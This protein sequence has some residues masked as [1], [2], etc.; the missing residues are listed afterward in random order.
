MKSC[1]VRAGGE[2]SS[3]GGSF[4]WLHIIRFV[5]AFMPLW[6]IYV[7]AGKSRLWNPMNG[8]ATLDGESDQ[9]RD[10][11]SLYLNID[12]RTVRVKRY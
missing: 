1:P 7:P 5:F 11:F 8:S 3:R 9:N 6:A 4:D 12:N 10:D 2:S